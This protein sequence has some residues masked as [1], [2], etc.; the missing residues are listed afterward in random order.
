MSLYKCMCMYTHT[1]AL[2]K[3]HTSDD[4]IVLENPEES[5]DNLL[6]HKSKHKSQ[7]YFI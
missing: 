1:H 6:K 2:K 7:L 4:I 5:R 3:S